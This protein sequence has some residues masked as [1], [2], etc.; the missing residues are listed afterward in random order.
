MKKKTVF[1]I[2]EV[3]LF[4]FYAL[5]AI[6]AKEQLSAVGV[7]IVIMVVGNG[8]TYIGGS[9]AHAWQKSKYF[10]SELVGK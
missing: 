3:V 1:W 8:A 10:K 5:T 7:T 2:T 4:I 9:V 6:I